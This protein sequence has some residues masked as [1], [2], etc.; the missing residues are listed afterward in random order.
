MFHMGNDEDFIFITC[1]VTTSGPAFLGAFVVA[2]EYRPSPRH[3]TK[4]ICQQLASG[5]LGARAP[6]QGPAELSELGSSFNGMAAHLEEA[7]DARRELV[8]WASP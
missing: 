1:T 8:A 5:D 6:Q 2:Q 7:F 4:G 3:H